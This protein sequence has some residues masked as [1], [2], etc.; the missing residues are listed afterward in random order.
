LSEALTLEWRDVSLERKTVTFRK[1]KNTHTRTVPLHGKVLDA[2]GQAQP[3]GR[4]FLTNKGLPYADRQKTGSGIRTAHAAAC[5]RAGIADFRIHDWRH[6][7]ASHMVMSGCDIRTLMELGG[8]RTM[9]MV[10][11][12]AHLSVDHMRIAIERIE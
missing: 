5:R 12:Y 3:Q 7:W 4:V 8:W 11:R 10:A 1:T 9:Q 2:L 6:H